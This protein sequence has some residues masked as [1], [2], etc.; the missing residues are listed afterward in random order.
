MRTPSSS[1]ARPR[2]R[3]LAP[4]PRTARAEEGSRRARWVCIQASPGRA[5][6]PRPFGRDMSYPQAM[7]APRYASIYTLPAHG[8]PADGRTHARAPRAIHPGGR[9]GLK[10]AQAAVHSTTPPPTSP[11]R[12]RP[13]HRK[14]KARA[15]TVACRHLQGEHVQA[16]P[17]W[18]KFWSGLRICTIHSE[19][20]SEQRRNP[21]L[22]TQT[23]RARPISTRDGPRA[24]RLGLQLNATLSSSVADHA[25]AP[26]SRDP[27]IKRHAHAELK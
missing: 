6:W 21:A 18:Q 26:S 5:V 10:Q 16:Q 20:A 22:A 7:R 24:R 14:R 11:P 19:A 9:S 25:P 27:H 23:A 8:A 15:N 2:S 3:A 4:T 12:R 13:P 1:V 17:I